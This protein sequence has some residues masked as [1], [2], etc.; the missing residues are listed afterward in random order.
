MG[1]KES[2]GCFDV[3]FYNIGLFGLYGPKGQTEGIAQI[4][5]VYILVKN[6]WKFNLWPIWPL[7]WPSKI[8][9]SF[10]SFLEILDAKKVQR[11]LKIILLG[12]NPPLNISTPNLSMLKGFVIL[13]YMQDLWK[14]LPKFRNSFVTSS[15]SAYH[16]S[17]HKKTN[18]C[19]HFFLPVQ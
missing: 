13:Y 17:L 9:L 16:R 7:I 3:P 6:L 11:Y 12:R 2:F 8:L 15:S 18:S 1:C 19:P 4:L 14:R 10:S 5:V